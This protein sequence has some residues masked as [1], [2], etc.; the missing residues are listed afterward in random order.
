VPPGA[1]IAAGIETLG[2]ANAFA[3]GRDFPD[4][5]RMVETLDG[6]AIFSGSKAA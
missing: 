6:D 1:A 5:V 3:E 2:F 4:D